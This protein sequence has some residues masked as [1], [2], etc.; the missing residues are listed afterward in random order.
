[1]IRGD[2]LKPAKPSNSKFHNSWPRA[3]NAKKERVN[4]EFLYVKQSRALSTLRLLPLS[5]YITPQVQAHTQQRSTHDSWNRKTF[6]EG[7]S[8]DYCKTLKHLPRH[9]DQD[10]KALSTTGESLLL[11]QLLLLLLPPTKTTQRFLSLSSIWLSR[12]DLP[13]DTS[14][15]ILPVL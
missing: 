14:I 7:K 4:L 6:I 8:R 13:A 15:P 10:Q 3:T 5:Q 2:Y 11:H 9:K 12:C 1:M